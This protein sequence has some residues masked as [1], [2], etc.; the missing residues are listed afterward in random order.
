ML[1]TISKANAFFGVLYDHGVFIPAAES[2]KARKLALEV[3]A[4]QLQV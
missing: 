2:I 3:C 1:Y 4:T